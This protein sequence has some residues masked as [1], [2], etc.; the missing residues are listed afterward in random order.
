VAPASQI[1]HHV[2]A[3][4]NLAVM[5]Q[6][7]RQDAEGRPLILFAPDETTRAFVDMYARQSVV[8]IPAPATFSSTEHLQAELLREPHSLV[9]TQLSGRGD[10][11]ELRRFAS[12]LRLDRLLPARSDPDLVPAW[13]AN[14]QLQRRALYALPNGRRYGL[15]EVRP[16]ASR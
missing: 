15:F 2:D 7:L 10:A 9:L 6:A 11:A 3:W 13:V 5:G 16:M 1:Y 4:Q 8:L 14:M 12:R